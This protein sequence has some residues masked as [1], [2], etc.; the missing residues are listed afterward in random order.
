MEDLGFR[1]S[2]HSHEEQSTMNKVYLLHNR[3]M[4]EWSDLLN[5][6]LLCLGDLAYNE[7]YDS[8]YCEECDAWREP[9]CEDEE[10]EYCQMRPEKPS[11]CQ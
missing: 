11:D 6:C 10:C 9:A 2:S 5:H 7:E 8:L 4:V 3:K 1:W